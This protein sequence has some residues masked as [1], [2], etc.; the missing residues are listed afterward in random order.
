MTTLFLIPLRQGCSHVHLL[1]DVAPAYARVIGAEGNLPFL[2]GIRNDALLCPTEVV[3]E[4]VLEPHSSDEQEVP[5]VA[6]AL[7]NIRHCA[8]AGH[9]SVTTSP[10][11]FRH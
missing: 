7:L 5:T 9:L 2:R 4:Q 6:T 10:S 3:V 11:R 1:D 8:V